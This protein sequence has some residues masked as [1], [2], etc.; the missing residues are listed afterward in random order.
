MCSGGHPDYIWS[1][2]W[3]SIARLVRVLWIKSS[4]TESSHF[5]MVAIK[6]HVNSRLRKIDFSLFINLLKVYIRSWPICKGNILLLI[7]VLMWSLTK[8]KNKMHIKRSS[9][10]FMVSNSF[11]KT[12]FCQL[13]GVTRKKG[14]RKNETKMSS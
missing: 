9:F 14:L 13:L 6:L 2:K 10:T 8:A 4:K 11:Q 1:W 12:G 7:G 3:H 5:I